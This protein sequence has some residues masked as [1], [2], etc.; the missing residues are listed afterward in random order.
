MQANRIGYKRRWIAARRT[1]SK[2]VCSSTPIPNLVEFQIEPNDADQS[3]A[4][5]ELEQSDT[6][7]FELLEPSPKRLNVSESCANGQLH[8]SQENYYSSSSDSDDLDEKLRVD[9]AEWVNAYQI[10]HNAADRLLKIL[11]ES[12]HPSLPGS[13]RTLTKTAQYD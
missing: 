3:I 6:E 11:K 13:T 10:K 2:S 5:L 1:L 12:G 8:S 4:G 7:H 9:L